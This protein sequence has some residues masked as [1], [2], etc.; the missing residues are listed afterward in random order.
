MASD[1]ALVFEIRPSPYVQRPDVPVNVQ[2]ALL[3]A[4][5]RIL[6][7]S[8]IR[9]F[10]EARERLSRRKRRSKSTLNS[11][12]SNEAGG[13][14]TGVK[15][16]SVE[17]D[18]PE[19]AKKRK[20]D[21]LVSTPVPVSRDKAST[22]PSSGTIMDQGLPAPPE[23][24]SKVTFGVNEVTK[25]LE[26]QAAEHRQPLPLTNEARKPSIRFIFACTEDVD[27]PSMI[28]H[29]PLLVASC[30][31]SRPHP[32]A[33]SDVFLV[34]LPKNAEGNLTEAAGLRRTAVLALEVS[35]AV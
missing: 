31:A 19:V 5:T 11:S 2:N 23:I 29:L 35:I 32:R 26:V 3:A 20:I 30:N 6:E 33:E 4:L 12:S 17:G 34:P 13:V 1:T 18:I 28:E 25:R 21:K 15:R 24:L 16:K 10:H 22:V 14:V 9:A 7:N 27:P 8:G